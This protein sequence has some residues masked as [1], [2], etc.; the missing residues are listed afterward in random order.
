[1]RRAMDRASIALKVV[2]A[3]SGINYSTLLTYFPADPCKEPVQIPQGAVF[4][5]KQSKA[6]PLDILNLLQPDGLA[7]VHVPDEIDLH[8]I[9]LIVAEIIALKN[10][11]HH[12][13]SPSGVEIS[14][15]EAEG[16]AR[17]VAELRAV[18]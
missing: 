3:D 11:A 9:G 18:V 13:D 6:L 8:T 7:L 15:C 2:A 4:V 10:A 5:L 14:E 16:I 17:K 12:P 1:M